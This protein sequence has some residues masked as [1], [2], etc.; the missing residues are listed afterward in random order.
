MRHTLISKGVPIWH[1]CRYADTPI[2][3]IAD[4]PI[5]PI[6]AYARISYNWLDLHCSIL[7]SAYKYMRA[8]QVQNAY[9][10]EKLVVRISHFDVWCMAHHTKTCQFYLAQPHV[11][12][13]RFIL[14]QDAF[15]WLKYQ[16]FY[17]DFWFM[18]SKPWFLAFVLETLS[19]V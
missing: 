11:Q 9:F 3:V 19:H 8:F 15:F 10:G 4:M 13:L 16:E 18:E 12:D 5:L 1:F 17:K 2:L 7:V 14:I 6:F